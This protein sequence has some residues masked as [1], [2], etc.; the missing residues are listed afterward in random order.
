MAP[1]PHIFDPLHFDYWDF[2]YDYPF[3]YMKNQPGNDYLDYEYDK[4]ISDSLYD[5]V[6]YDTFYDFTARL[7][8]RLDDT[9][10]YRTFYDVTARL[11]QLFEKLEDGVDAQVKVLQD[12]ASNNML[13]ED[14]ALLNAQ[15]DQAALEDRFWRLQDHTQTLYESMYETFYETSAALADRI[16]RLTERLEQF[17]QFDDARPVYRISY[18]TADTMW[19]CLWMWAMGMTLMLF[20]ATRIRARP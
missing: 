8:Q 6:N 1:A 16:Q 9:V 17:A 7:S 3:Q 15:R 14:R 2:S 10:D 5:K 20:T 4:P 19:C 11:S 18:I 12:H 13:T